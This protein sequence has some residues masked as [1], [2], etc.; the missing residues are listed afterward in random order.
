MAF[1]RTPTE[2][3]F[4]SQE[5]QLTREI[6]SRDGGVSGKDEDLLN[7]FIEP[8]RNKAAEDKR[9]FVTKRPGSNQQ[10]ASVAAESV[11]GMFFWPDQNKLF[12][13]VNNDLYVY[14]VNTAVSTTLSNVFSTTTGIVGF[15]LFLYDNN[16]SVVIATDGTTLN[17]IDSTNTVTACVDA[18]MPVHQPYPVFLDGY[19]FVAKASSAD[20]YNSNL[21]DPMLW[22]S[23]DFISA[24]M[25][26]DYVTRITKVNNYLVA[27]GSSSIEY[28]WDSGEPSGSPLSRNDTPIKINT[29]LGGFAQY[30][31]ILYYIGADEGGS[32]DVY[33]LKDFKIDAV[34]TP[35]ISRY[36]AVSATGTATWNGAIV[37]GSGHT[38]YA[39]ND[40]GTRTYVFDVDTDL[41]ARWAF[42]TES[43]FNVN[44]AVS[45][46]S[47]T[48][49]YSFFSISGDSAVYKINAGLYQDAGTTFSCVV[50][51]EADSFGTLNR[52]TMSQVAFIGDRP[53]TDANLLIQ[54]SDDDYQ[55]YNT[56][57]SINLKQDYPV[58]RRLGW[59]RQRIFKL[60]F[61]ANEMFRAQGLEVKINKGRN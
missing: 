28:F 57:V 13:A 3:T 29:Y 20:I 53:A 58:V 30:G 39:V 38:F 17:K 36:L 41:W 4:S 18:D 2:D 31:N 40:G 19:L 24:E 23:G 44:H 12:Y 47:T 37:S 55:S 25:E 59:F 61:A 43:I 32:P 22:T 34:G 52:K 60:T 56:G 45:I 10:I 6:T 5:V 48:N 21:N 54:W 7:V 42:K 50:T 15:C 26:G 11:R 16:T 46:K 33:R 27:M 49:I 51:T 1:N 8:V 14:N 35:T 9:H